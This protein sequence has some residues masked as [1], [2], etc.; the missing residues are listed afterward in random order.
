VDCRIQVSSMRYPLFS[1]LLFLLITG[2]SGCAGKPI[3]RRDGAATER[4]YALSDVAKSD[5]DRIAEMTQREVL[6]GLR[7]LTLK[8]YKRN[9]AEFRKAGHA[10]ADAA[11]RVLFDELT[12]WEASQ[13]RRLDWATE[14]RTAF[15]PA[16]PGDRVHACMSALLA[17]VMAAYEQRQAFYLTDSLE[18]QKLYN[19][20]R[21]IEVVAW[22]LANA[23]LEDGRPVLLSNSLPGET[24]NLSFEREFGKLIAQ[25]DLL[26]L[27][28]E[29]RD[30]RSITRVLHNVAAFVFLP[31]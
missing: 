9:P 30:N 19:S 29:D 20:A 24:P 7:R 26:A 27:V 3:E 10:D 15:D 18:A 2:L 6:A 5:V 13:L 8:L 22:K 1:F 31:L 16:H 12:R 4:S 11:T 28:M 14:F 25:Q 23:R 21:N 17:M